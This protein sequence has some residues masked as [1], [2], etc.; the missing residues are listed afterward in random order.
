[1]I[2]ALLALA[3]LLAVRHYPW[4]AWLLFLFA[5]ILIPTSSFFP[6]PGQIA[7]E[8]R[9]YL[10]LAAVIVCCI[11][12]I[13]LVF[14][15]LGPSVWHHRGPLGAFGLA[16][17]AL[18]VAAGFQT[19]RRNIDYLSEYSLWNDTVA[20]R[21]QNY[22]P[23]G[24]LARLCLARGKLDEAKSWGRL[25]VSRIPHLAEPRLILAGVLKAAGDRA[26]ALALC[27]E[28]IQ[29]EPRY[30]PAYVERSLVLE[31][32]GRHEEALSDLKEA[33]ALAP[34]NAE[35]LNNLGVFLLGRKRYTEALDCFKR[36]LEL[37]SQNEVALFNRGQLYASVGENSRALL[38]LQAALDLDPDQPR[39][40]ALLADIMLRLGDAEKCLSLYNRAVLAEPD[41]A[42]WYLR[43]A[44]CQ[45][46][47]G[48]HQAALAD[49]NRASQ[50]T[51]PSGRRSGK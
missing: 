3:A 26:G 18:A 27:T 21:P 8:H 48:R 44:A 41:N 32:L 37:E 11:I 16:G 31:S 20:K 42:S 2:L 7:A 12:G 40:L 43:R 4:A 6:L 1:V 46:K 47:L 24:E 38:D 50:L 30:F 17:T 22:R 19:H 45:E 36:S 51:D 13:W 33:L 23:Y 29:T 28:A 10:P 15:R 5:A 35:V 25:A 49:R 34:R 9:M 39:I 14:E